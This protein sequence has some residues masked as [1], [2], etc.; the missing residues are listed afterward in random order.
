MRSVQGIPIGLD[1]VLGM[2]E[3]A[4]EMVMTILQ[5]YADIYQ[6]LLAVPV[7]KGYKTEKEKFAGG[8]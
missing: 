4:D 2:Q 3:E 7:I 1:Q 6:E 5:H 8:H